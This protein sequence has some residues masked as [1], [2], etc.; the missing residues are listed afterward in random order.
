LHLGDP[1]DP[2]DPT[3]RQY[4]A[5]LFRSLL[6]SADVVFAQTPS[7]S[8]AIAAVGV[9]HDRIVLQGL[10]VD[11]AECTGGDRRLARKNWRVHNDE[12]VIG[13]LANNSREKGTID[14]VRACDRLAERRSP[15]RLV[16][17]GPQMPNFAQFMLNRQRTRSDDIIQL[18]ALTD[19]QKRD[20]LAGIDVFALPSRSDSFGL[21]LLEA[22]ANGVPNVVYRAGGPADLIRHAVDGLQSP[23]GDVDALADQ[24]ERMIWDSELR[25]ACGQAG[26]DRTESEFRWSDKLRIAQ[27]A[28]S[29]VARQTKTA[30]V[31]AD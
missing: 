25:L 26:L 11:P 17:A 31:E 29:A 18:G 21:V 30:L 20:F 14:L 16:L 5:P 4:T 13:H 19:E 27:D 6:R 12:V 3:R 8:D 22:W 1:D 15:F 7:E 10:G 2:N 28:L 24:L 9:P 23:C